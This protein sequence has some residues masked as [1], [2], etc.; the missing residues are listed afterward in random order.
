[1]PTTKGIR[2]SS[3]DLANDSSA[4]L[5]FLPLQGLD[6]PLHVIAVLFGNP[7]ADGVDFFD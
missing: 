4:V 2:R 7:L 6:N 3:Y 1:V 5:P